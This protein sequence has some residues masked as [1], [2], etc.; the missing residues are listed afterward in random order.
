MESAR[1]SF[2]ANSHNLVTTLSAVLR[3][4]SRSSTCRQ[5]RV[6]LMIELYPT[7]RNAKRQYM[8]NV[9][10]AAH[11]TSSRSSMYGQTHSL[12]DENMP[13]NVT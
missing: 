4:G 5:H 13:S 2:C 7:Q 6:K 8:D 12:S 3:M 10:T 9:L 1:V 11:G